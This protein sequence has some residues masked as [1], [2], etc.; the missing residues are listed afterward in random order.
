MD[1]V[2]IAGGVMRATPC[3]SVLLIS[4]FELIANVLFLPVHRRYDNIWSD[5]EDYK[6]SKQ[7]DCKQCT[8]SFV[9]KA[10]GFV[11]NKCDK[12]TL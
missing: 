9:V 6:V 4:K 12:R 5:F 1:D 8:H 10:L 2:S 7:D 3:Y 11:K